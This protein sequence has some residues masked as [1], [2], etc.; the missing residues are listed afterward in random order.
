MWGGKGAGAVGTFWAGIVCAGG[1]GKCCCATTGCAGICWLGCDVMT[2]VGTALLQ[3]QFQPKLPTS[4][5]MN[6]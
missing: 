3:I 2:M 6:L 4:T 5:T 1:G